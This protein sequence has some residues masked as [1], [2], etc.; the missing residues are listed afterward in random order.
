M[1]QMS[2]LPGL[3]Y[4]P[5]LVRPAR[6]VPQDT[7]AAD[8]FGEVA[9]VAEQ[10]GTRVIERKVDEATREGEKAVTRDASGNIVVQKRDYLLPI[11]D[12]AYENAAQLRYL[13]E[14]SKDLD[15]DL[16]DAHTKHAADPAGFD[17]AVSGIKESYLG[18]LQFPDLSNEL[19]DLIDKQSGQHLS[20]IRNAKFTADM[21]G[22]A[23][24]IDA[25]IDRNINDLDQLVRQGALHTT[26]AQDLIKQGVDLINSKVNNPAF[27]GYT[28]EQADLDVDEFKS[29][30]EAGAIVREVEGVYAEK[31]YDGAREWFATQ[32]NDGDLKDLPPQVR[33]KAE[34]EVKL[35]LR[36]LETD[37][38]TGLTEMQDKNFADLNEA[39]ELGK[40]SLKQINAAADKGLISQSA[41][42]SL[43]DKVIV[44]ESVD[45][46]LQ[47][48]LGRLSQG[49]SLDPNST[50]DRKA[51]DL[52][53]K[54]GV[55]GGQD[56]VALAA[57]FAQQAG[58]LPSAIVSK[59]RAASFANDP[60]QV[61]Q[62]LVIGRQIIA[63]APD[64]F[65]RMP[66]GQNIADDIHL[67][68]HYT[69]EMGLNEADAVARIMQQRDPAVK[70]RAKQVVDQASDAIGKLTWKDAA[71]GMGERSWFGALFGGNAAPLDPAGEAALGADYRAAVTDRVRVT[72]DLESAKALAAK[73]IQNIYGDSRGALMKFPPEKR[74]PPVNGSH[75]YIREQ[76][77]ADAKTLFPNADIGP[78]DVYLIGDAATAQDWASGR[79]PRYTLAVKRTVDGQEVWYTSP[80]GSFVASPGPAQAISKGDNKA[81]F[82]AQRKKDEDRFKAIT[83]QPK[84]APGL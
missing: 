73:D 58:V 71:S 66:G 43:T 42:R 13:T 48:S 3:R 18:K 4:G 80:A 83:S 82:D 62:G 77:L 21:K 37:R 31:G 57:R 14:T 1:A 24:A 53:F 75:D 28:Q 79:P 69:Q 9:R 35:R 63:Q 33:D 55:E 16:A 30:L 56:P 65:D 10:I 32:L 34:M 12:E 41:R 49:W 72:G 74:Y 39:A 59:V 52:V 29:T 27:V 26:E 11:M 78:D 25:K 22:A 15:R 61:A 64:V 44:K 54:K 19:N 40:L 38:K 7:G 68:S 67:F 70:A 76:A 45:T 84:F 2:G 6:I 46:D 60:R 51:V 23:G 17:A 36:E 8:L 81:K 5:S 47:D 20:N 50:S